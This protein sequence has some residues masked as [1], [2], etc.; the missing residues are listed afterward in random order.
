MPPSPKA[1]I[2]IR[3]TSTVLARV[4][5]LT[6]KVGVAEGMRL[7]TLV[8]A[9][10]LQ[11]VDLGDPDARVPLSS[12]VALLQLIAKGVSDPGVGVRAVAAL[13]VRDLG[14]LGYLLSY[15]TT[16]GDA[17]HRLVRYSRVLTE[18][19][20]MTSKVSGEHASVTLSHHAVGAE[21]PFANDFRLGAIVNVCRQITGVQIVPTEVMFAYRQPASTLEHRR[22]FQCPLRFR[23]PT[24]KIVFARRDLDLPVAKGNEALA[25]YLS[26]YADQVLGSLLS[27]T[28]LPERVR[29]AIWD[30]MGSGRP[31]LSRVAAG[32]GLPERTLQRRLAEEGTSLH[33]EIEEV[34][35][36]MA[37]AT[38]RDRRMSVEEVA[39]LLGY[40]EPSTF[41]RSFRR[42]TGTTPHQYRRTTL[43]LPVA[44]DASR[45]ARN[46]MM[47]S[48]RT[49]DL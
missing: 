1:V 39:F 42:W 19:F 3:S 43:S 8:E 11:G 18:A 4:V 34:R 48:A 44:P 15:S 41:F 2:P 12:Q 30:A 24:S 27:G 37:M 32:V 46:A 13:D 33:D 20:E 40:A 49:R 10:G 14:V 23:Q 29:S 28:S 7:D 5:A 21:L 16:L 36:A 9:A 22:F 38:L 31:T 47:D 25:R 26:E 17:L 45:L 6:L 35:K